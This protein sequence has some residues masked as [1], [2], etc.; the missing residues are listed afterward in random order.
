V[1][2]HPAIRRPRR[3]GVTAVVSGAALR[4]LNL[5]IPVERCVLKIID[6]NWGVFQTTFPN[7]MHSYY[8]LHYVSG[9]K[10]T[11]V[12]QD[13]SISL[14]KGC[15]Y[16]IPPRVYHEQ[17]T[18]PDDNLSEYHLA[19]LPVSAD[20]VD[21]LS[22]RLLS[23]AVCIPDAGEAEAYFAA[24]FEEIATMRYGYREMATRNLQAVF[25]LLVRALSKP[26]RMLASAG[27]YPEGGRVM[28]ADEAFLY[29]YDTVTLSVLSNRLNLSTRQ[30]QRFIRQKYGI[31]FS[32]LKSRA[33][34]H[35]A[36]LLLTTTTL[37]VEEICN[38]VGYQNGS[39][40]YTMFKHC[41]HMTPS[42]Y[43]KRSA[44]S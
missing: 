18:N 36:A 11:L 3:Q 34:I 39:S 37:P 24:A 27:A 12:L 29:E 42:D 10:G 21:S 19:F 1:A 32:A 17:R 9:G 38:R 13:E 25:I 22:K 44:G 5:S 41:Y 30:T 43:R 2:Q 35:H 15:V 23:N 33:K 4:K 6:G 14:S 7:H 28:T 16:V 20:P 8:E 26:D 31:P 40:F